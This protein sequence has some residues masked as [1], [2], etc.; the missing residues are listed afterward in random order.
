MVRCLKVAKRTY[1]CVFGFTYTLA[2]SIYASGMTTFASL[3][4]FL[5][6]WNYN[7]NYY[8]SYYSSMLIYSSTISEVSSSLFLIFFTVRQR[9]LL[10]CSLSSQRNSNSS[11]HVFISSCRT[12]FSRFRLDTCC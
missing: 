5:I 12:Q 11:R 4:N 2:R 9:R 3:N 10:Y 8:S 1:N 7:T 6:S